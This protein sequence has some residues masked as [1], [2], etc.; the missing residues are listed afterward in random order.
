MA[1]GLPVITNDGGGIRGYLDENCS[2]LIKNDDYEGM[3]EA[4]IKLF[5]NKSLNKSYR[6]KIRLKSLKYSWDHITE[7]FNTFY[8]TYF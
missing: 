1:C 3:A 5:E 8:K 4:V 7:K 6:R 2:L